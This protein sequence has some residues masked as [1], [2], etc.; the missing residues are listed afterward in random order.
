MDMSNVYVVQ[1]HRKRDPETNEFVPVYDLTPAKEFGA[2]IEL[3]T[4]QATP[5]NPGP[6]VQRLHEVL[7]DYDPETDWILP[8]GNPALIGWA[9]AIASEYSPQGR[10]RIL[11]WVGRENAYLPTDAVLFPD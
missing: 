11:Q 1:C 9:I 8:M 7:Q 3:L 6:V 4:P 5:F 10:V 2:V